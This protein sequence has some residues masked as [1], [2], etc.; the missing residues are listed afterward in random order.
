MR[1]QHA[2]QHVHCPPQVFDTGRESTIQVA[3]HRIDERL[4]DR[5][6]QRHLIAQ[7]FYH[8][9][10]EPT[11]VVL[12]QRVLPAADLGQPQRIGEVVECHHRL[13]AALAQQTQHLGVLAQRRCVEGPRLRLD[14][15]PLHREADAV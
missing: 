7:R 3:D 1:Q 4:V 10:R 9:R 12:D 13:Q 6:P 15:A 8:A 5:A 11:E 14:A 2:A